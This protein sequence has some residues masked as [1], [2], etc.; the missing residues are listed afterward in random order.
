[1]KSERSKKAPV[2]DHQQIFSQQIQRVTGLK[3]DYQ[4]KLQFIDTKSIEQFFQQQF[5]QNQDPR[6]IA[7][8]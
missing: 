1:M 8:D 3:S 4:K 7:L 5:N 6:Q 2:V